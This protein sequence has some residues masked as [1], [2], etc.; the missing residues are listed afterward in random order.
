[1][2]RAAH[3]VPSHV[4][5]LLLLNLLLVSCHYPLIWVLSA[6][7]SGLRK[8]KHTPK[9]LLSV[10]LSFSQSPSLISSIV[11][12]LVPS[13]WPCVICHLRQ[14]WLVMLPAVSWPELWKTAS[15]LHL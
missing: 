12:F 4:V 1:M 3:S 6:I 11:S 13:S 15:S 7:P 8:Q 14:F 10:L 5:S 9:I 2:Q